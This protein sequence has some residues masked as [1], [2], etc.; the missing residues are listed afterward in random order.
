[1]RSWLALIVVLTL[2]VGGCARGPGVSVSPHSVNCVQSQCTVTF[3]I[4][5]ALAKSQSVTYEIELYRHY[6]IDSQDWESKSVGSSSGKLELQSRETTL[7]E[8]IVGVKEEP[9]LSE[10]SVRAT[11][12]FTTLISDI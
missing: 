8:V 1:M 6:P 12:G 7:V 5:S 3:G 9:N 2:L 10:I 4:T 11:R